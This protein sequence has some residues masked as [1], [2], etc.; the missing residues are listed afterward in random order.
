MCNITIEDVKPIINI[1][2][3]LLTPTI[4]IFSTI[5][6]NATSRSVERVVVRNQTIK[7]RL[8]HKIT[9]KNILYLQWNKFLPNYIN[10]IY[11]QKCCLMMSYMI[12]NQIL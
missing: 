4:A 10:I 9:I 7:H 8:L 2:S 11:L 5:F 12:W 6:I 3:A 1:L